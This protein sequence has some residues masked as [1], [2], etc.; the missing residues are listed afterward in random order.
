VIAEEWGVRTEAPAGRAAKD[1]NYKGICL[2]I[3]YVRFKMAARGDV[4]G[5]NTRDPG[6]SKAPSCRQWAVLTS[7]RSITTAAAI[8]ATRRMSAPLLRRSR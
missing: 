8:K 4:N 1:E 3:T 2:K 6:T 7:S 5:V